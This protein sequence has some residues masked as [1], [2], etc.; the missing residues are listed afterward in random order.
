MAH[1]KKIEHDRL[2]CN[3]VKKK[4]NDNNCCTAEN[5]SGDQMAGVH[6]GMSNSDHV[7][8]CNDSNYPSC[9]IL[10]RPTPVVATCQQGKDAY[11]DK[12]CC[13]DDQA[14]ELVD[15]N[16]ILLK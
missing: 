3:T 1:I 10:K 16:V 5:P 2:D 11:L 8:N 9:V 14:S 6:T 12:T 13:N 7:S 15:E 4:F